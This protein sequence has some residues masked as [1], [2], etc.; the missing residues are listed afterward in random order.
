VRHGRAVDAFIRSM[1]LWW[2]DLATALREYAAERAKPDA[3]PDAE[4]D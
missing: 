2:G 3:K 4:P 1:G